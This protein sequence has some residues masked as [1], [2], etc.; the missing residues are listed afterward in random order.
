MIIAKLLQYV[1]S[2]L[3]PRK[4]SR[5]ID[6]KSHTLAHSQPL[7]HPKVCIIVP[8]RDKTEL[9]TK[10]I[11]SILTK[12]DY[13]NYEIIVVDNQSRDLSSA[14]Y[15]DYLCSTGIRVRKFD[16]K[17]NY[18]KIVNS[19]IRES[20]S[21]IICLLNNDT[22]V[23][24]GNW[25]A[26]LVQHVSDPEVG[27]AGAIL[28]YQSGR[29]QH[30]GIA[31]GF[32]GIAG[33]PGNGSIPSENQLSECFE[34]SAVTFACAVFLRSTF[35]TVGYMDESFPSGL[36]DVIW[37]LQAR[38]AGFQAILCSEAKLVHHESATRGLPSSS[39]G[40]ILTNIKDVYRFIKKLP[41]FRFEDSF[42]SKK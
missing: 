40:S 15:F 28:S 23:V 36:N 42:F 25:L 8:T 11:N 27:V 10:C 1:A 41:E 24:S 20:N 21:E 16:E 12:T 37:C 9:L 5:L 29:I 30:A 13:S 14:R 38:N 18:S 3:D 34:V 39:F 33:Y 17:F 2:R 19:V 26:S 7:N 6:N 32:K 4:A 31:L 35:V 22:E